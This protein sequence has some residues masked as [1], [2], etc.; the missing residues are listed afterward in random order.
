MPNH[1]HF[2]VR[3]TTLGGIS[4]FMQKLVTAYT[5]YFNEK[6]DRGGSLVQRPFRASH[7]N[8]DVYLQYLYAYLHLNPVK[9][10]DPD[11]WSGKRIANPAEAENFLNQYRF[12]SYGFYWGDK[13]FED[14]ILKS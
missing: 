1:Y 3:E 7:I 4:K 2:L 9:T 13:R 14:S 5:M 10:K 12:S 6:N 11:A 8:D